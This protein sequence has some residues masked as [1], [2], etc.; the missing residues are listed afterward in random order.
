MMQS[1][2]GQF[3]IAA[4]Q[5]ADSNFCRSVVLMIQHDSMGAFGL[6]VNHQSP[7]QVSALWQKVEQSDECDCNDFVHV[8]GPVDGPILVLHAAEP[9]SEAEVIPGVFLASDRQNIR[10]VILQKQGVFRVFSGYSG[11]GAGQLETE[12][13]VGGWFQ[14][15]ASSD[16]VFFEDKAELWQHVI[17]LKGR[18]FFNR[19]L[20]IDGS[21]GDVNLN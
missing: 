14:F 11:W 8:G 7:I 20:G 12:L 15:P 19:T 21:A 1:L 2:Q 6:I 16:L 10:N 18:N 3:L 5:L 13:E 17:H 4:P 9:F